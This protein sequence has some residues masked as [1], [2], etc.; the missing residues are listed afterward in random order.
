MQKLHMRNSYWPIA[1]Q[2]GTLEITD[3]LC[4]EGIKEPSV[5]FSRPLIIALSI[6]RENHRLCAVVKHSWSLTSKLQS[7]QLV[8]D[9]AIAYFNKVN[10]CIEV[11][12]GK[13]EAISSIEIAPASQHQIPTEAVLQRSRQM[14]I[15]DG[16]QV[17]VI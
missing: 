15:K 14:L 13:N 17:V 2:I 6:T 1:F 4:A 12:R 9:E 7:P 8:G 16:I 5:I 11:V 3:F 10:Q